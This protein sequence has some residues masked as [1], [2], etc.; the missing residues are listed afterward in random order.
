VAFFIDYF[1][2][3]RPKLLVGVLIA[4]PVASLAAYL[5][6]RN[7]V[8]AM[9]KVFNLNLLFVQASIL[10]V[11]FVSVRA[12]A[13]GDR[14][15]IPILVGVVLGVGF[16]T[17][18]V[19]YAVMD[20]K[21]FAWLQGFGFFSMNISL[22]ITLT[23]RSARLYKELREYSKD[24]EDKTRQ[25]STYLERIE[26]TADS[27]SAITAEID[28]DA[29]TAAAS[30]DSVES[31]A[32]FARGLDGTA[33]QGRRASRNLDEAISMIKEAAGEIKNLAVASAER[34]IRIRES[35]SDIVRRIENGV[36]ANA[37]VA[38]KSILSVS[39]SLSAQ[40][41]ATDKLRTALESLSASASSIRSEAERQDEDGRRIGSRMA[42]LV[43]LSNELRE[44]IAGIAR[45]NAAIADT[46]KRLAT[47]SR[48]GKDAVSGLRLL[49]ESRRKG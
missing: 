15:A 36:Q 46:T 11:A 49:L 2:L 24:I 39:D 8:V 3:K 18:D 6:S 25:L 35:V 19:I 47:V 31:T 12:V 32:D 27:V 40:R 42:E 16:G 1:K 34:T 26:K 21:P 22:F 4:L 48:D 45:E 20:K 37:E 30:A 5:I 29:G 10:F 28:A 7:D 43:A 14:G 38:L 44:S 33:E 41:A 23:Q 17:H 9:N 13:R